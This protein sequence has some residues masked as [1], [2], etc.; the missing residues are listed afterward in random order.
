MEIIEVLTHNKK[1]YFLKLL[2]DCDWIAGRY[3]LKMIENGDLFKFCGEDARLYMLV[4]N[5]EIISFCTFVHQDEINAPHMSPWIG[6]V[7]TYPKYRG[8]RNF[9]KLLNHILDVAKSEGHNHLFVSTNETGL[10][11]K[12]GFVYYDN[13][14]DITGN[15][16][17]IYKTEF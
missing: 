13:M 4:N 7:Y 8:Q 2:N 3:L 1:D 15:P 5:D 12:Y 6:F 10:Y 9:G 17:R 16:S 11:E 14:N